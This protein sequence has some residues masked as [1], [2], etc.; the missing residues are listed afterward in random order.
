MLGN[1]DLLI[2]RVKTVFVNGEHKFS[3]IKLVR[4]LN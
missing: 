1:Y 3:Y 4:F 2:R